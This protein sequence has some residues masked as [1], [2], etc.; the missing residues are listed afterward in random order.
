[1]LKAIFGAKCPEQRPNVVYLWT[2]SI[3]DGRGI[4]LNDRNREIIVK[5]LT[6]LVWE[7]KIKVYGFV[8]MPNH[9]HLVWE[10]I[11]PADENIPERFRNELT[12]HIVDNLRTNCP[13]I[14]KF[15]YSGKGIGKYQIW[16]KEP[17]L[18]ELRSKLH[19]KEALKYVHENPAFDRWDMV[20]SCIDFKWSSARF[21]ESGI[22]PFGFL[23]HYQ[24][25]QHVSGIA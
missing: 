17:K 21:Y 19:I 24:E 7:E 18:I 25:S 16:K 10:V 15:F 20:K 22:D 2:N 11:A 1:M 14:L 12:D 3:R 13:G 5:S 9:I 23:S 6:R 4:L 8:I